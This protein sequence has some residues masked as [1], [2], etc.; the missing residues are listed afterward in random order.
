MMC[1]RYKRRAKL[2]MKHPQPTLPTP[3]YKLYGNS[4]LKA[5]AKL[6]G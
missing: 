3:G 2:G 4:N 5:V 1:I 6:V